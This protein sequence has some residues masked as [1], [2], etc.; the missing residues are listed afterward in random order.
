MEHLPAVCGNFFFWL[1][2]LVLTFDSFI[3]SFS[4]SLTAGTIPFY[5][6]KPFEFASS[7]L[8]I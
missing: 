1:N 4:S 5:K 2:L 8:F 6:Q 3:N 7:L